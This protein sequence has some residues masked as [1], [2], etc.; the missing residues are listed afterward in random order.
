[1]AVTDMTIP[2]MMVAPD[3]DTAMPTCTRNFECNDNNPCTDDLCE[4]GECVNTNNEAPCED[5]VYCNGA[6]SCSE[7]ICRLGPI[8]CP[9]PEECVEETKT[10][11]ACDN[12]QQCPESE[13]NRAAPAPTPIDV[14]SKQQVREYSCQNRECVAEIVARGSVRTGVKRFTM[15]WWIHVRRW[16]LPTPALSEGSQQRFS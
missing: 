16:C 13:F 4:N 2:D 11:T 8:P 10:C 7:G 3:A 1:M 6:E 14:L 15:W 12:D 9:S 5:G